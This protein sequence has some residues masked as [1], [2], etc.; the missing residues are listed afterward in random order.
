[1]S[2]KETSKRL[3]HFLSDKRVVLALFILAL[4]CRTENI[5]FNQNFNSDKEVQIIAA[6]STIEGKGPRL[7]NAS[8]I[9]LSK[10]VYT[11]Y[12]QWPKGYAMY[13]AAVYFIIRNVYWSAVLLDLMAVLLYFFS[14]KILIKTFCGDPAIR[15]FTFSMFLILNSV[16]NVPFIYLWSSDLIAISF[17][18]FSICLLFTTDF[19]LKQWTRFLTG[20]IFLCLAVYTRYAYIPIAFA[21]VGGYFLLYFRTWQKLF[22]LRFFISVFVLA[23]FAA[24]TNHSG[25]APAFENDSIRTGYHFA[26]TVAR[27]NFL[28]PVQTIL[29]GNTI[30]S[31]SKLFGEKSLTTIFLILLC[32]S[33]LT[34]FIGSIYRVASEYFRKERQYRESTIILSSSF[35]GMVSV[36][37]LIYLSLTRPIQKNDVLDNWT[38]V[39]EERYYAVV[40]VTMLLAFFFVI[41]QDNNGSW[42]K[43]L[44]LLIFFASFGL[45]VPYYFYNKYSDIKKNSAYFLTGDRKM[46]FL[47]YPHNRD[48]RDRIIADYEKMGSLIEGLEKDNGIRPVYISSDRSV[49]IAV[50]QGAVFGNT[51]LLSGHLYSSRKQS[52]ILK[53]SDQ[54]PYP[55]E[56]LKTFIKEKN[57]GSIYSGEIGTL[58]VYT[59]AAGSP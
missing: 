34:V 2:F 11:D 50:L 54:D 39:Q 43:R 37:L 13:F 33:I 52:I 45:N 22:L 28:F 58:Y 57:I 18:L 49:R 35:A 44:I 59:L 48:E 7:P 51:D 23:F 27:F 19:E 30:H 1:M 41:L 14:W 32:L 6:K 5:I 40:W 42:L 38:Y 26:H 12:Y 16:S 8:A 56:A 15:N 21:L 3:I 53:I 24:L 25:E 20:L 4:L 17:Y 9:D 36:L 46:Y 47:Q 55:N 10:I 31:F 29:A